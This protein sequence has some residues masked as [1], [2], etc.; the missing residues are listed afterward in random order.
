MTSQ[1]SLVDV[2]VDYA[3]PGGGRVRAL[4]GVTTTVASGR[5]VAVMGATGSG[6]STLAAVV[7]GLE[8]VDVG[9][10]GRSA[11]TRVAMV[12]QRPESAL[13]GETVEED[14]GF[15]L[16]IAG[17]ARSARREHVVHALARVGLD[18]SFLQRDPLALSGGEQRRVAIAGALV[19]QPALLVL[20][21]PTAGLDAAARFV[22][23]QSLRELR[24]TGVGIVL[25]THDT[26][27]ASQLCERLIVLRDGRLAYDGPTA[28]VCGDVTR[29]AALGLQPPAAVAIAAQVARRRGVAAPRTCDER[30]LVEFLLQHATSGSPS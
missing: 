10:V 13:F 27:E 8:R 19:S 9:H 4:D 29:S 30:A 23:R 20:D 26:D 7:A 14:V 15:A 6:K 28:D 1:V 24:A 11:A 5:A 18:A 16:E 17:L 25:V 2:R 12:L 22:L 3:L 21:E